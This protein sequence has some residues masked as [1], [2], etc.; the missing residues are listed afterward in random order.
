MRLLFVCNQNKHRSRTAEDIFKD[1]FETRSAGLF[2]DKPLTEKE[3]LWADVVLVME[4]F[5]R[6]E[7]AKRFPKAY[8]MKRILSL[9]IPDVY[10]YGQQELKAVLEARFRDAVIPQTV[11]APSSLS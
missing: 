1:R 10:R 4:D 11:V 3:L 2:N 7:I 8:M 9:N 6:K 5:Q